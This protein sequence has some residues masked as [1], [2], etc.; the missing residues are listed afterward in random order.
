MH[1]AI[2]KYLLITL[3]LMRKENVYRYLK[4]LEYNQNLAKEEIKLLQKEKLNTLLQ[5][6]LTNNSY[7]KKKYKGYNPINDFHKLSPLTKEELRENYVNIISDDFQISQLDL[8][9]TSGSTGIPLQFYRDRVVFGY[10]LAS[11]YRARRWWNI[12]MGSKE[13]MLWGVP[14]SFKGKIKI[15]LKDFALNR[16]RE[17]EYNLNPDTLHDFYM[18][19]KKMKPDYIFGYSS[20]VYEFALYLTEMKL[21]GNSL[22]LKAAICTSE[23]IHD[24]QRSLIENTL[25]CKVISE[26]GAAETGIISYECPKGTYH[27]CDDCVLIEIVDKNNVPLP[28]GET[29]RVLVTVLNSFSAPIIRYELGDLA[30]KSTKTCDCGVNLS[31]LENIQGRTSDVVL[32]PDGRIYHSII[33]YYIMKHLTK[34]TGGVKQF[35]VRQSDIHRLEFHIVKSN[36]F[37]NEVESFIKMQIRE[38]FGDSMNTEFFYYNQIKREKSGKLRDFE[39]DLNTVNLIPRIYGSSK[40]T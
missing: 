17:R 35:K 33:F 18:K 25:G 19:I 20:M 40:Q 15:K 9:E 7:Y 39:T 22:N 14:I 30:C 5:Y 24:Y 37:S 28:D 3:E 32:T 27:I 21:N 36:D 11:L 23:T 8:V 10:S 29:G 1:K 38:K 31:V 6:A 16:F 26:Y 2:A 13:A 4:E 34:R 12:D